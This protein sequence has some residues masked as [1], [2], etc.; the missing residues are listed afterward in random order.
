[1]HQDINRKIQ[2]MIRE[3]KS[4]NINNRLMNKLTK[5]ELGQVTP[6]HH[7]GGN[8][9]RALW[10]KVPQINGGKEEGKRKEEG[11]GEMEEEKE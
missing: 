10:G 4:N 8:K 6:S 3:A 1:M 9:Y 5:R 7:A 2:E 11:E